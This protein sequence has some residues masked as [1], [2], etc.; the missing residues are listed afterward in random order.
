MR[1]PRPLS[2]EATENVVEQMSFCFGKDS[3]KNLMYENTGCVK[4]QRL[5]SVSKEVLLV[6]P[7]EPEPPCTSTWHGDT[8]PFHKT[9]AARRA[10]CKNVSHQAG[11]ETLSYPAAYS[12]S[13]GN[14]RVNRAWA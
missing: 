8:R 5:G 14:V 9:H 11:V 2:S 3:D 1:L 6:L 4:G 7:Q 13:I 10:Q 12:L